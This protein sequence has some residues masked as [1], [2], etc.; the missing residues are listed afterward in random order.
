MIADEFQTFAKAD[1]P[2]ETR[3]IQPGQMVTKDFNPERYV[4][5]MKTIEHEN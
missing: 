1:L 3:V 2:K 5:S 4:S